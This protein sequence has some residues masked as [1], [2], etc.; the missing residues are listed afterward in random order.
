MDDAT[1]AFDNDVDA[2][3]DT[4]GDGKA[5]DFPNLLVETCTAQ[6]SPVV[7]LSGS[8][9]YGLSDTHS[10]SLLHRTHQLWQPLITTQE[11]AH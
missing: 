4:D 3:T 2:W 9:G 6:S 8:H 1:D 7:T 10:L 5:D 11:R